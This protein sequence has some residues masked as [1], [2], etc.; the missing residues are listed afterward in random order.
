MPHIVRLNVNMKSIGDV[1]AQ[2]GVATHVLRHWEAEGLLAPT[3]DGD[4]RRYTEADVNR[5]AA[6]M[7][8]KQAG[9]TLSG[10]R[11]MLSAPTA[12]ARHEVVT[13]HRQELAERIALAQAAMSMIEGA[14]VCTHDDVMACPTFLRHLGQPAPSSP[15]DSA[16]APAR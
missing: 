3:R 8:G 7:L 16:P 14:L 4:R 9:F 15:P 5:V 1:A 11:A 12:A 13:R 6:I 2:F 10:I